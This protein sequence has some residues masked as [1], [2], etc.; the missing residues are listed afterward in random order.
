MA[1]EGQPTK[2]KPEYVKKLK[3]FLADGY[4]FEAFAGEVD[5]CPDTI[6]EWCKVHPEF[7]EAKKLGRSKGLKTFIDQGKKGA[8]G[9]IKGF[10]ATPWIFMMKNIYGW[11]DRLEISEDEEVDELIWVR[12]K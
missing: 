7:S 10:N 2:Y 6:Y 8:Y 4:P 9:K 3:E 11:K 12:T 1:K 5:V